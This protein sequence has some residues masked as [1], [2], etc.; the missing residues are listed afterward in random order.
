MAS[1]TRFAVALAAAGFAMA[2]GG[3]GRPP[4]SEG[5]TE[6][7]NC[8]AASIIGRGVVSR[9]VFRFVTWQR[10]CQRWNMKNG[11]AAFDDAGPGLTPGAPVPAGNERRSHE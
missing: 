1:R 5:K 3:I 2:G 6:R 4:C 8:P 7:N 9:R 11:G 10:G